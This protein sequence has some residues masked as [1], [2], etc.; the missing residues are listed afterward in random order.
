MPFRTLTQAGFTVYK[1]TLGAENSDARKVCHDVWYEV[2][3]ANG[4]RNW[5][6]D[7]ATSACHVEVL[8]RRQPGGSW[9]FPTIRGPLFPVPTIRT[10]VYVILGSPYLGKLPHGAS[11]SA[12]NSD[13]LISEAFM[14]SF[15]GLSGTCPLGSHLS[16]F[17]E[18]S[19]VLPA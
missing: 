4:D 5:K 19:C 16:I 2:R 9:W 1:E 15:W 18:K 17:P 8:H 12:V 6:Y 13:L 11:T 14:D 10:I 3:H 7:L